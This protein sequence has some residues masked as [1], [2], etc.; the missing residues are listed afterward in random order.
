MADAFSRF[1]TQSSSHVD[2][3]PAFTHEHLAV[4]SFL[5]HVDA[6]Y[7]Q[8]IAA[9]KSGLNIKQ[10]P[11]PHPAKALQSVWERLSVQGQ[12]PDE[13]IFLDSDKLLV[14]LSARA[15]ILSKLHSSHSGITKTRQLASSL[16]FWPGMSSDIKN[17]IS[18]CSACIAKLPSQSSEPQITPDIHLFPMKSVSV[19][20]FQAHGSHYLVMVDRFSGF[21]FC[22]LLRSLN[23][24]AVTSILLQWFHLWGFPHSIRSDAGPQFRTEFDSFC[25]FHHI[26]H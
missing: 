6:A 11:V 7:L 24:K 3:F 20:L 22:R 1:P 17:M 4:S 16:Y 9:L 13:L 12:A 26:T 5:S 18:S 19:D 14:P 25:S 15:E 2:I 23:T 21:P 8:I 10:L